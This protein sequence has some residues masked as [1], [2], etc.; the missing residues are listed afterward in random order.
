MVRTRS[1]HCLGNVQRALE[2]SPQGD[3]AFTLVELLVS[4]AVLGV[5]SVFIFGALGATQRVYSNSQARVEQFREARKAFEAMTRRVEQAT[6]N[7]YW[8]YDDPSNPTHYVR[9]SELHF[10]SGPASKLF[11]EAKLSPT[12]GHAVF[13]QAPMGNVDESDHRPLISTLNAWGYFLTCDTDANLG[14]IPA[15]LSGRV[16]ARKRCR[17]MEFRQPT[18]RLSVY[19]PPGGVPS[20]FKGL[21]SAPFA[22]A[23]AWFNNPALLKDSATDPATFNSTPIAENVIALIFS[24]RSPVSSTASG[25]H[26][27]DVAPQYYYDSRDY[28]VA[29]NDLLAKVS[30]HQLPPTINVTMVALDEKSADRYESSAHSTGDLVDANAFQNVKDY[31]TDLQALAEHLVSLRLNFQ[32]FSTAVSIRAAKWSSIDQ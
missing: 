15:F 1:S 3:A 4:V 7:T 11:S 31:D 22:D 14:T 13:F 6:L 5:M 27:Y 10:I 16:P 25:V 20:G 30:R 9:Q 24:P 29:S 23:T 28:L 8:D 18:E 17:L 12:L 26:D 21:A 19:T 32:V 2:A